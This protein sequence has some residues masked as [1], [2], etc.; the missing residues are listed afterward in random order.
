[1]YDCRNIKLEPGDTVVII[2]S[3]NNWKEGTFDHVHPD[4][5]HWIYF[6][7]GRTGRMN[8]AEKRIVLKVPPRGT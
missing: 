3:F 8:K 6:I 7:N 5:D 1:M 2:G 4:N